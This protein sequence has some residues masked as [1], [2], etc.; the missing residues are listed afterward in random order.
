GLEG[1][2]E[3][4]C[5]LEL[6][7]PRAAGEVGDI[8]AGPGLCLRHVAM[9]ELEQRR[10]PGGVVG[11]VVECVEVFGQFET[12]E[13]ALGPACWQGV[14]HVSAGGGGLGPDRSEDEPVAVAEREW[15]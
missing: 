14:E 12:C 13:H 2:A 9:V 1:L 3:H 8:E 4:I 15:M 10:Y 6:D 7:D 11:G 5:A